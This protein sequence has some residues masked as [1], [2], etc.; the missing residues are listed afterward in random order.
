MNSVLRNRKEKAR[1]KVFKQIITNCGLRQIIINFKTKV[2]FFVIDC[3][4]RI[5]NKNAFGI[6]CVKG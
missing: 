1:Q 2:T 4:F 6:V 5:M 3:I